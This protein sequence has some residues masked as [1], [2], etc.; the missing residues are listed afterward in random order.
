MGKNKASRRVGGRADGTRK[1]GRKRGRTFGNSPS[2]LSDPPHSLC[3]A[4]SLLIPSRAESPLEN[5]TAIMRYIYGMCALSLSL[6][7]S[8]SLHVL[9]YPALYVSVYSISGKKSCRVTK[10]ESL[11]AGGVGISTLFDPLLRIYAQQ[12]IE[13]GRGSN[14]APF[15]H[16][17]IDVILLQYCRNLSIF[18]VETKS[19]PSPG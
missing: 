17:L 18:Q 19:A 13:Q 7:L 4:L 3:L 5:C 10:W 14:G 6:S 11:G 12:D 15:C 9:R 16:Q 1:G 8:L 2:R